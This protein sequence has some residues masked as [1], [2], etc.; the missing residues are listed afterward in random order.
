MYF[1]RIITA[2]AMLSLLAACKNEPKPTPVAELREIRTEESLIKCVRDSS[3]AEVNLSLLQLEGGPNAQ[4]TAAINDSIKAFALGQFNKLPAKQ[5]L[6]SVMQQLFNDLTEQIKGAD[7]PTFHMSYMLHNECTT[8]WKSPKFVSIALNYNSFTGGAHGMYATGLT[9]FDL[10]TGKALT[11]SDI[12]KDTTAL[13]PLLERKIV[14][15]KK[16]ED[17][18]LTSLKDMLFDPEAP[19]AL[20]VSFC[21]VKEGVNV[22]YNPYEIMAYAFGITDFTLTWAELGQL[23]DP[24]KWE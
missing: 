24:K 7:D 2:L 1:Q 15:T 16:A 18:T 21:V 17:S 3:C 9:T 6:D 4:A 11:L 19:V 20:P 13:R 5:A 12:I 10:Q 8:V 22:I 14:E 23:A